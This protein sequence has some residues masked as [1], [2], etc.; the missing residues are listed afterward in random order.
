MVAA[1]VSGAARAR[2]AWVGHGS[3]F[4]NSQG[5][6]PDPKFDQVAERDEG[7][8]PDDGFAVD[9][10]AESSGGG[11][12]VARFGYRSLELGGIGGA[13]IIPYLGPAHLHRFD[14]DARH[15]RER[16][17]DGVEAMTA[18]HSFYM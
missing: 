14:L 13:L 11:R 17:V 9:V 15:R 16:L 8:D 3:S 6:A 1:I 2:G 18:A 12:L 5:L 10:E 4:T 7:D